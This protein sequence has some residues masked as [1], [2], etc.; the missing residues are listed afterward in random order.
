MK[1]KIILIISLI[2]V[3]LIGLFIIINN[4]IIHKELTIDEV[5][6]TESYSYLSNNVKSYIKEYYEETGE[7]LKTEKNATE[8]STY[9]NPSF[10]EYLDSENKDEYFVI[11][12]LTT[13][14]PV[15]GSSS[16]EFPSKFDLRDVNGKNYVTPNKN[17]GTEGLCWAYSTASLLE[18]HDLI[19]KNKSYDD[20]ALL[21]SEKQMD[22]ALSRD[23]LI[24]GNN[25][26]TSTRN[27]S[28]GAALTYVEK[29]L[30]EKLGGV[31]DSFD[32][33]NQSSIV[34][35]KK[36]HPSIVFN[37]N[38]VIY[39]PSDTLYLN[40]INDDL[41]KTELN[42]SMKNT[43]KKAI[44]N[45]GGLIIS[46]QAS[47]STTFK[48]MSNT[49]DYLMVNDKS[50]VSV[51]PN[52]ALHMIGWDDD[53]EYSFCY[54]STYK[55]VYRSYTYQDGEYICSNAEKKTGKGAW[56]LKNSWGSQYSYI[57]LTYDSFIGDALAITN[58]S[59]DNWDNSYK[60]SGI[61][62]E[63]ENIDNEKVTKIKIKK[64][65]EF[66]LYYSKNGNSNNYQEIGKYSF[67]DYGYHTIDLSDKNIIVNSNSRF[68]INSSEYQVYLLVFTE[69]SD[70]S[71]N[72]ST[73]NYTYSIDNEFPSND[74]NLSITIKT[75]IKGI[76][77][78]ETLTYKIKNSNNEY[79]DVNA[80]EV[81]YNNSYC[82]MVT[83]TITLK[84]NYAK[85]GNYVLE[86]IYNGNTSTSDVLLEIDYISI[87][88]SGTNSDP[89]QIENTSQFNM[90]RNA[91]YDNYILM[92]DLDF[93]YDTQNSDGRYYNSGNGWKVIDYFYGNLNGNNKTIKNLKTS[94]GLFGLFKNSDAGLYVCKLNE[95]GIHNLNIDN[96]NSNVEKANVNFGNSIGGIIHR[97][98]ISNTYNSNFSN[99]SI[100]NSNISVQ[101]GYY[102]GGIVGFINEDDYHSD[103]T[104]T[105]LKIDNWYNNM[106]IS[107]DS[108]KNN[109]SDSSSIGG[110]IGQLKTTTG[111]NNAYFSLNNVKADINIDMSK[112]K[113]EFTLSD[114]IA[115]VYVKEI[116]I[117]LNNI[118]G[119][120]SNSTNSEVQI[121]K[122]AFIN[123]LNCN[124]CKISINGSRSTLE[125]N[126]NNNINI[127]NSES[128]LNRYQIAKSN[129]NDIIYYE[130]NYYVYNE[131]NKNLRKVVFSDKFDVYGDKIPTLKTHSETYPSY[132]K[133]IRISAL[134]TKSITDL[135]SNNSGSSNLNVYKSYNC[136]L[137]ICNNVTD[138][139]IINYNNNQ[140]TGLKSGST[141]L[142]LSDPQ[143]GYL[144][145]VTI[146]VMDNDDYILTFN[147]N[148]DNSYNNKRI[149]KKN[150]TY[151]SLPVINRDN[152]TFV[153]WFTEEN[154]GTEIKSDTIFNGSSDITLY[155]HWKK[156]EF[157]VT[158][159]M[160]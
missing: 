25:I 132:Y 61:K 46:T 63:N 159:M 94:T 152:Y 140:F 3:G 67:D 146:Y 76:I 42:E 78:G 118:I 8:N 81:N 88:G 35:M 106:T 20:N 53:Y 74:E 68:R 59:T 47:D 34:N 13:Y 136:E 11:P 95:C 16:E 110:L 107:Y 131:Y 49:D 114:I 148:Y 160:Q 39:E 104:N 123:G 135:I 80:Y 7:I 28:D 121:N 92:N 99:L 151:G 108:T 1:K 143:I 127:T 31:S 86:T 65:G 5:L 102:V 19:S 51:T 30:I 56:I 139:T 24:G 37:R 22:Y 41:S 43:L 14:N 122:N 98:D 133:E 117:K 64:S 57:Y 126:Q 17:Q 89:W 116:D 85:K 157:T 113:G 70:D 97:I 4:N 32:I 101:S 79:L 23:G 40:N 45:Y 60:Y 10:I 147:N 103:F 134:E 150:T 55:I 137:D 27:L 84:S 144:D 156:N 36:I 130:D 26:I 71:I 129:Y 9:L 96:L 44:Y 138:E 105:V 15:L 93:E 91:P 124:K 18:T 29:L 158:S 21:F 38:N 141:T 115:N 119:I 50:L 58:Y 54:N 128:N 125:Y 153:G 69:N 154:G 48:N 75:N 90:I 72:M 100:S 77:D 142:I 2:I 12:S 82:N 149:I 62:F 120:L 87:N 83:P 145:T 155:A 52:H 66:T 73:N 33:V 112:A 6:E 111:M 109:Y